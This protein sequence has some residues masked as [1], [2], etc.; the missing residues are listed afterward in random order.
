MDYAWTLKLIPIIKKA[1]AHRAKKL[2]NNRQSVFDDQ[3]Q[4]YSE[5]IMRKEIFFKRRGLAICGS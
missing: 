3:F 5:F 4:N 2:Y 1:A